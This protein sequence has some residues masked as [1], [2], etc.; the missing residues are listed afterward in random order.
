MKVIPYQ[1]K[2]KKN[3]VDKY[4]YISTFSENGQVVNWNVTTKYGGTILDIELFLHLPKTQLKRYLRRTNYIHIEELGRYYFVNNIEF[5]EGQQ[6]KLICHE[7]V[8]NTY[9][10]KILTTPMMIRRNSNDYNG[11]Y[12]DEKYPVSTQ[13]MVTF[14]NF[15]GIPFSRSNME[16][17]HRPI[18]LVATGGIFGAAI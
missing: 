10:S 14:K 8:L 2:C 17:T 5:I 15:T 1:M 3:V 18:I 4:N 7:D 13:R 11:C 6:I 12:H 9:A 16:G